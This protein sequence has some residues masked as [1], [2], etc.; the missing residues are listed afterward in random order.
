[1]LA[2]GPA[3]YSA[4]PLSEYRVHPGQEQRDTAVQ[5]A[6]ITERLPLV[7]EARAAG[8]LKADVQYRAA[9]ARVQ[10]LAEQ[11]RARPGLSPEAVSMLAAFLEELARA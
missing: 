7:R 6:C 5:M 3:F 4:T 2:R 9:L 11:W 10:S 8:F 1:L